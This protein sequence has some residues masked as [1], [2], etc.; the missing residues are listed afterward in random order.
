MGRKKLR[1]YLHIPFCR[2]KCDYCDFLSAPADGAAR[3]AYVDMLIRE[4]EARGR[5]YGHCSAPSLFFGGGTPSLLSGADVLRVMEAVGKSFFLEKDAEITMECNPGTLNEKK[6]ADYKNAGI[7]RISLGLQSAKNQELAL[8]GRIHGWEDFLMSYDA[9][10]RAGFSNLNVDLMWGLPGQTLEDWAYSLERTARLRPEHISA[11]SLIIE[12]GTPFFARF[13]EDDR[14][15]EAGEEPEF[16]PTEETERQMYG[17]AVSY[18]KGRGYRQYEISNY[19]KPGREC[20]HNIGYWALE[21]YLGLGLGSASLVDGARFSNTRELSDYLAGD[22]SRKNEQRLSRREQMEEFMFLGL[23]MME[24]V[25]RAEFQGRFGVAP[26]AVYGRELSQ[27][28]GQGLL[29]QHA[30]RIALTE[31]GVSVSNYVMAHFLMRTGA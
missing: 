27:L 12:E 14:R 10:R 22:F 31:E 7:N 9:V 20:R 1:L 3:D 16:L 25:S 26:E 29:H 17:H 24:G 23:R 6:A 30:G 8:L 28:C 15:R 4:I 5:E 19:A 2:K 18:L 21:E 13:W 11:Y